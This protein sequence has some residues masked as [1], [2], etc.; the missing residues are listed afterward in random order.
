[1][2]DEKKSDY[3]VGIPLDELPPEE[4]LAQED[5]DD[6]PK[7]RDTAPPDEPADLPDLFAPEELAEV[8]LVTDLSESA[9]IREDDEH[10]VV[11]EAD[12]STVAV[13]FIGQEEGGDLENDP[14]PADFS[15]AI[16]DTAELSAHPM[17]SETASVDMVDQTAIDTPPP[18]CP[19]PLP[20]IA[21]TRPRKSPNRKRPPD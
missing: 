3:D 17:P 9:E 8:G 5:H 18:P 20:M 7:D 1:M 10:P 16:P 12:V 2:S 15:A 6:I 21:P 4:T 13:D 11:P 14:E 19:S